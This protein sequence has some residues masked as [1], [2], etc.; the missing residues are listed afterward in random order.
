MSLKIKFITAFILALLLTSVSVAYFTFD[1]VRDISVDNQINNMSNVV[2]LIDINLTTKNRSIGNTLRTASDSGTLQYLF[3]RTTEPEI[4]LTREHHRYLDQLF[5]DIG[6]VRRLLVHAG[7]AALEISQNESS[8]DFIVRPLPLGQSTLLEEFLGKVLST[9]YPVFGGLSETIPGTRDRNTFVLAGSRVESAVLPDQAILCEI[10]T[11]A[12]YNILPVSLD[13]LQAQTSFILDPTGRVISANRSVDADWAAA[14]E[15]FGAAMPNQFWYD[16][17]PTR[18]FVH[19]QYNGLTGWKSYSVISEKNFFPEGRVL[20]NFLINF[21]VISFLV[22]VLL[23][24][25]FTGRVTNPLKKL[26]GAMRLAR[27]GDYSVRVADDRSDEIGELNQAF[28][29]LQDE[30]NR[31]I[32]EVYE[33]KLAL[34]NAELTALQAQINPH[35]LYNSLDSIN[36]MLIARG[37]HESSRI[38]QSLGRI[39]RYSVDTH[40][41]FV[42]LREEI[43]NVENYLIIQKNRFEDQLRYR[44]AIPA[45]LADF[46]VPRLIL[47]PLVENAIKHGMNQRHE[48]FIEITAEQTD[49]VRLSVR[50][51]GAGMTA[52]TLSRVL[53]FSPLAG[54]VHL[55]L[56]NVDH[57]IKLIHGEEF[58][59]V[60]TSEPDQ[61]SVVT[62]RLPREEP[63]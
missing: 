40:T 41:A 44:I 61:G 28:N 60:I 14:I 36:W 59:V 51:N 8:S 9:E 7:G 45:E 33:E 34:K 58:G 32:H 5:Q 38:I 55:G 11:D 50:D 30:I 10:N 42:P 20:Q 47:Q 25:L 24:W 19:K 15:S 22:S 21:G 53:Q 57:R 13:I 48:L 16:V 26:T 4:T 56:A 54:Q 12:Y 3:A 46:Q 17:E 37:D 35:F 52:D 43:E 29:Y 27:S 6:Y 49:E 31:L 62:I 39:L 23:F 2:N 1:V 18:F 63:S